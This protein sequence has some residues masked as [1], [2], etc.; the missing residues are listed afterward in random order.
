LND[1]GIGYT[2]TADLDE[3]VRKAIRAIPEGNWQPLEDRD[4]FIPFATRNIGG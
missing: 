4:G 1:E 2:V 3:A